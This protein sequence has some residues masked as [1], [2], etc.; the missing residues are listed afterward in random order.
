M[1]TTVMA[2]YETRTGKVAIEVQRHELRKDVVSYSYNG[3]YGAGSGTRLPEVKQRVQ[4]SLRNR[5]GLRVVLETQEY[6][7]A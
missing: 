4:V 2:K 5:R 3:A 7:S 6:L 1:T